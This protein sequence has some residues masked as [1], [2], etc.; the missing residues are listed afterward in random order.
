MY[1][2]TDWIAPIGKITLVANEMHITDLWIDGQSGTK[3][4][5]VNQMVPEKN[6]PALIAG[7]KWLKDYFAGKRPDVKEVPL[8]PQ[9]SEFQK[10]IWN[11]L[12]Q[13]PY[14]EL[15]SYGEIAQEI[16]RARGIPR[17]AAQ[18][19][20]GAVGHNPISILIP[21]HRVV[22]SDGK[23]VGYGGGVPLKIKLLELEGH[24]M[25]RKLK[26]YDS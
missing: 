20:G 23:L 7:M 18:A 3:A 17:M 22:G 10:G 15:V 8:A 4:D 6:H 9:G 13:I 2:F 14:G 5:V 12:L 26:L 1:Y 24:D 21:C 19:V 16:A 11:R 25:R